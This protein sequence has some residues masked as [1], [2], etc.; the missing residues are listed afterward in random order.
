MELLD[1]LWKN[2]QGYT[3]K[4]TAMAFDLMNSADLVLTL[5]SLGGDLVGY[6]TPALLKANFTQAV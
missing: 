5:T 4:V 1:T 2:P 6:T 3:Y